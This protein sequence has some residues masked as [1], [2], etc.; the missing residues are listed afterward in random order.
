MAN[1]QRRRPA[2]SQ[3]YSAGSAWVIQAFLRWV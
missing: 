1:S 3:E 2:G